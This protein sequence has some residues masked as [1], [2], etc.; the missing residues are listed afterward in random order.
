MEVARFDEEQLRVSLSRLSS[1]RI[2]CF[3]VACSGR[4]ARGALRLNPASPSS[5]PLELAQSSIWR[6]LESTE[7]PNT[8][9]LELQLLNAMPGEAED[10][11]FVGAVVE[12]ACAA[13]VYALRSLR[14]DPARNA[15]RCASRAY[16]TADRYAAADLS[17]T[18]YDGASEARILSHGVV[19]R[20][21]QRQIR[22]IGVLQWADRSD[23]SVIA[24]LKG[25][26]SVEAAL[27]P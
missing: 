6:A 12:D 20:E 1:V 24:T 19:Q 7:I 18:A 5:L 3:A 16:E 22:D 25:T 8:D 21:L 11:S 17:E 4:L 9:D 2:S 13:M 23:A 14:D 26:T 27:D 10:G 15:L